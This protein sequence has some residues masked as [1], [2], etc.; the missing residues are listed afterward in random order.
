MKKILNITL[1]FIVLVFLNSCFSDE[2]IRYKDV[3]LKYTDYY[4]LDLGLS[5]DEEGARIVK[6]ASHYEYSQFIRDEGTNY[7]IVYQY[8]A[9]D[10]YIGSDEVEIETC[11]GG[12][13]IRCDNVETLII[14][15]NIVGED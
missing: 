2:V 1:I 6:Q 12:D 8:K 9:I 7:S 3:T 4:E 14:R 10:G 13:G 5:G 15:F 11:T